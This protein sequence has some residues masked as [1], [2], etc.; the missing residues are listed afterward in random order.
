M[1]NIKTPYEIIM[2][3]K[4]GEKHS[5]TMSKYDGFLFIE[6]NIVN[7]FKFELE[8][9]RMNPFSKVAEYKVTVTKQENKNG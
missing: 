4:P 9:L 2:G 1:D 6:L 3:L 7:E 5:F 8:F